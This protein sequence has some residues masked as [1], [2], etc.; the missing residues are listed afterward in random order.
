MSRRYGATEMFGLLAVVE[1]ALFHIIGGY[2][3][4]TETLYNGFSGA[5]VAAALGSVSEL[6]AFAGTAGIISALVG[7]AMWRLIVESTDRWTLPI[8]GALAGG[9]TG[10]LSIFP[11]AMM[12]FTVDQ[13]SSVPGFVE[14]VASPVALAEFGMGFVLFG[15]LGTI[16]AGWLTIPTAAIVGYFLGREFS[17]CDNSTK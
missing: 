8:R 9:F 12:L 5:D 14:S 2:T 15:I 16:G 13:Y 3:S 17:N 11:I 4:N 10:W 6:F 7:R 1:A